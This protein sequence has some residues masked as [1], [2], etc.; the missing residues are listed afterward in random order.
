[1]H[2]TY[3]VIPVRTPQEFQQFWSLCKPHLQAVLNASTFSPATA[4]DYDYF[5]NGEY[6]AAIKS[7]FT[8]END[9][10]VPAFFCCNGKII[11]FVSY[12]IYAS[13]NGQCFIL[14]YNIDD[15]HRNQ[16]LG[17]R[18]FA[19]LRKHVKQNGAKYFKLNCSNVDNERF[20]LN[21]GFVKAECPD[22]DGNPIYTRAV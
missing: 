20:W 9:P 1:M 7:L 13:E 3:S 12:V 18:F 17:K 4:E 11:G 8:R 14:E 5:L 10:F 22:E 21:L 19:L 16:G 15:A 6:L 2:P